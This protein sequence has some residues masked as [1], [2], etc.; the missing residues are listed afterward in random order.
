MKNAQK[1]ISIETFSSLVFIYN[2]KHIN[3]KRAHSPYR[4]KPSIV[5]WLCFPFVVILYIYIFPLCRLAA[6]LSKMFRCWIISMWTADDKETDAKHSS[7]LVDLFTE[8]FNCYF[9]P[10]SCANQRL[11]G[12]SRAHS[13][14]YR[15]IPLF[16][17]HNLFAKQHDVRFVAFIFDKRIYWWW[18]RKRNRNRE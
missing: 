16:F 14:P 10:F 13:H 18:N 11:L 12:R 7:T 1:L 4:K 17:L 9:R 2:L 3:K 5:R 6:M 8:V 15:Y